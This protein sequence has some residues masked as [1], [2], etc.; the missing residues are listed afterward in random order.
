MLKVE[1]AVDRQQVE[2]KDVLVV[3]KGGWWVVMVSE[4]GDVDLDVEA[5]GYLY[6]AG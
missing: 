5:L 1:V 3:V 2:S 6:V 4:A